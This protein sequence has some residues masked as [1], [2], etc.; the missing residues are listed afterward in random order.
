[1]WK[2]SIF[3]VRDNGIAVLTFNKP[4]QLNAM[5]F[6]I[7]SG[8]Q[9]ACQIVREDDNI[10][11]FIIT[12]AGRGFSAGGNIGQL[13]SYKDKIALKNRIENAGISVQRVY[14]LGKPVIAAVNGPVAGAGLSLMM[15]CDLVVASEKAIFGFTFMQIAFCPDCGCSYLL[16][17]KVGYQKAAEILYFGKMLDSKEA[18]E[19]GLVNKVAPA[20]QELEQ[21]LEWAEQLIKQPLFTVGLDKRLLRQASSNTYHQQVA[22]ETTCQV[23]AWSSEDFK[24]GANAFLEK[25]R[26]SFKGR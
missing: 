11:V 24:E 20:G 25:R 12:G 16:L 4:E 7:H 8:I 10:K 13:M 23:L 2:G 15:A 22:A 14:D 19:L 1:M 5:D 21:A 6:D 3:E 26:P 18:A 9:N 17:N